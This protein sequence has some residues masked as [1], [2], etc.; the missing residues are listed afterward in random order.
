MLA[1]AAF[2]PILYGHYVNNYERKKGMSD[3]LDSGE[4]REFSSGAVRD[5]AEGKGRMDLLPLD[6]LSAFM[7]YNIAYAPPYNLSNVYYYLWK[8]MQCGDRDILFSILNSF[9]MEHYDNTESAILDLSIHYEQGAKKYKERN[10]EKGIPAH[11]YVDS[12]LRHATKLSRGDTDEP[13]N[14][15][16]MWNILGLL[17]TITNK[18]ECNDLLYAQKEGQ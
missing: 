9:V 4:R 18:P 16:F 2:F 11:C 1:S 12:A 8:F 6:V 10:W 14:R 13:H 3:I 5:I 7:L 15:A 17:W